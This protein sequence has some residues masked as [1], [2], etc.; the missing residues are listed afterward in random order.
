MWLHGKQGC[1][2]NQRSERMIAY[3]KTFSLILQDL[4][5][6]FQ[7]QAGLPTIITPLSTAKLLLPYKIYL[8]LLYLCV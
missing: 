5:D 3:L 4:L 1:E 2:K 8:Q 7:Q 6:I